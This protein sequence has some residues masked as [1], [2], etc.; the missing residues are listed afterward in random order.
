M[1]I[2]LLS[3]VMIVLD[4]PLP[5]GHAAYYHVFVLVN[6]RAHDTCIPPIIIPSAVVLPLKG[7]AALGVSI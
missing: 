3:E 5:E 7:H 2:C 4:T 6:I 1:A